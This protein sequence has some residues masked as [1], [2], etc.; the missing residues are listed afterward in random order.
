M[1]TRPVGCD[2]SEEERHLN[3]EFCNR[4]A[5]MFCDEFNSELWA[6]HLPQTAYHEP[7]IWH[8]ISAIAALFPTPPADRNSLHGIKTYTRGLQHYSL[9]VRAIQKMIDEKEVGQDISTQRKETILT[10]SPFLAMCEFWIANRKS[11]VKS[12]GG[13]GLVRLWKGWELQTETGSQ[14]VTQA[15]LF[16]LK[17]HASSEGSHFVAPSESWDWQE[18]LAYMSRQP[19]TSFAGACLET[20]MLLASLHRLFRK[21]PVQPDASTIRSADMKRAVYKSFVALLGPRLEQF[22]KSITMCKMELLRLQIINI[23]ILL[24]TV[25]LK[26][27]LSCIELGWDDFLPDFEQ[28]LLLAEGIYAQNDHDRVLPLF[29]PFLSKALHMMARWCREPGLRRRIISTFEHHPPFSSGSAPQGWTSLICTLQEIEEHAWREPRGCDLGCDAQL[30]CIAGKY[31]CKNHRVVN[32]Q[33]REDLELGRIFTFTTF[34]QAIR[35]V[36]GKQVVI[37]APFWG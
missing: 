20:E 37:T 5:S 16:L 29:T 8:I 15:T 12:S 23:W 9:S 10:H 14:A 1:A 27:N 6:Q 13:I 4:F 31:V 19:I 34:G 18:A 28:I 7:A 26:V 33:L 25:M 35:H 17:G 2:G 3:Y 21:L 32:V 36:P 22:A 30:G 11:K 24:I